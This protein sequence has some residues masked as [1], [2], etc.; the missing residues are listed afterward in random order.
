MP[1]VPTSPAPTALGAISGTTTISAPAGGGFYT[2]T[3]ISESG[4][5]ALDFVTAGAGHGPVTV[6]VSGNITFAGNG[7]LNN[8]SLNPAYVLIVC[9]NTSTSPRQQVTLNGNGNAYFGLYCPNADITLNGGGSGG[10][11]FGAIVGYSIQANGNHAIDI[12]YDKQMSSMTTTAITCGAEVS[13]STPVLPLI[14][15]SA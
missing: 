7:A 9:T 13:R 14:T 10:V 5:G 8:D 11:I 3:S 1:T 2:A 6:F 4:N 12:H 15:S